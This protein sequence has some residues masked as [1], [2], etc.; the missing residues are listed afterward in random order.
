MAK[1]YKLPFA[2][3]EVLGNSF[4][5]LENPPNLTESEFRRICSREYGL[6]AD[7]V[8]ILVAGNPWEFRVRNKDGKEAEVSG[9]GLMCA[10][11]YLYERKKKKQCVLMTQ[12]GKRILSRREGKWFLD[13]GELSPDIVL[14]AE[15]NSAI[16]CEA[17]TRYPGNPHRVY[18]LRRSPDFG[19]EVASLVKDPMKENTEIVWKSTEKDTWEVWVNERGVGETTACGSGAVAVALTLYWGGFQKFPFFLR[20][21]GGRY[22]VSLVGG[23]IR[24]SA[25]AK[26]ICEG[27]YSY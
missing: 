13:W 7:G 19:S 4:V 27:N 17:F 26:K 24:V 1:K 22:T 2:K 25:P 23:R 6:G 12:V 5:I 15:E 9:N 3:Y 20:F 14:R 18:V 16:Q 21:P 11:E 10:A 8:I